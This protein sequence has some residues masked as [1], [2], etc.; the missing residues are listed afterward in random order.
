[1]KY[2]VFLALIVLLCCAMSCP[3]D[4]HEHSRDSF[5]ASYHEPESVD[6]IVSSVI[7]TEG[8]AYYQIEVIAYDLKLVASLS[9]NE[10]LFGSL[11]KQNN[12]EGFRQSD[13]YDRFLTDYPNCFA[14]SYNVDVYTVSQWDESHP[15]HSSL[16]DLI[17]VTGD[18]YYPFIQSG[19]ILYDHMTDTRSALYYL[20]LRHGQIINQYPIDKP[21]T[22]MG[23][24][25]L[26]MVPLIYSESRVPKH[27]DHVYTICYLF[28]PKQEKASGEVRLVINSSSG[29]EFQI[30]LT[31]E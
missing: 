10:E 6:A 25:D 1:M 7:T 27:Y 14:D 23:P 26:R 13:V 2:R 24:D 20:D 28:L 3:S 12:D 15:A 31:L 21:L 18:S 11:C 8:E 19:Y 30:P 5:I 17:W 16:N 9:A 29:K 4:L 22:E